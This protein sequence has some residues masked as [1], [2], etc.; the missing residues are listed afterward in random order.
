MDSEY[1]EKIKE[2]I[3]VY[4][5][6]FEAFLR[7]HKLKCL[8]VAAIFLIFVIINCVIF[9]SDAVGLGKKEIIVIVDAGHGGNDPGKVGGSGVLEKD[10]N[11][12]IAL[13]LKDSLEAYGIKVILT[14]AEDT[15]LATLGATNKKSSDMSNR[16]ELINSSDAVCFISIH[17]NSYLD[18]SV[19]GAQVFYYGGSDASKSLAENLQTSLINNVDS[20]N[21]RKCKEG[22]DYYLL[23]KTV[24]PGV[25]VECGFLSSPEEESKL[26]DE[27]Y[28]KAL[29]DTMAE[30]IYNLYK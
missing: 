19:K 28:Q 4:Y 22:N 14:R 5:M 7:K 13:K 1:M 24:I 10:L 3:A 17:Q 9:L 26:T 20:E 15:N 25:I 18:P 11:L 6:R 8:I 16:V 29:A 30:T 2:K 21:H 27:N 23:R 12:S